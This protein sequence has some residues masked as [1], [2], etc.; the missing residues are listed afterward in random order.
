VAGPGGVLSPGRI[1]LV[2]Q[3]DVYR[4]LASFSAQFVQVEVATVNANMGHRLAP[5]FS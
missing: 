1:F 2:D 4:L 3:V 5:D